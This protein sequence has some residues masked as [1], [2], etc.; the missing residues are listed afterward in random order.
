MVSPYA[1]MGFVDDT[2]LDYTSVIRFITDNWGLSTL[3]ER[4]AAAQSFSGAFDFLNPG[5][6]PVLLST[7]REGA[8]KAAPRRFII[9]FAYGAALAGAM[10]LIGRAATRSRRP[11]EGGQSTMVS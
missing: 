6:S 4:D 2:Q 7:T 8:A 10:L 3:A 11:R 1:R 5:R 9:F